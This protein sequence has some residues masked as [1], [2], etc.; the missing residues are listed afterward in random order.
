MFANN[1]HNVMPKTQNY[2][3]DGSG[4][5]TYICYDNGGYQYPSLKNPGNKRGFSRPASAAS[6]A[7]SRSQH[8]T[9]D[10][11]GRDSYI[12]HGDGGMHNISRLDDYGSAFRQ[13]LRGYS[14]PLTSDPFTRAHSSWVDHRRLHNLR[15]TGAIARSCVKRLF[16][17]K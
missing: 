14:R 2:F 10:G 12:K 7:P 15:R 8:Y 16:Y 9:S 3:S 11:S 4:R 13:S 6:A 1:Y 5:D 17:D